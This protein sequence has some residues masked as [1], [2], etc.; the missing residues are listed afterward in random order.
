MQWRPLMQLKS[1]NPQTRRQAVEKLSRAP[2]SKIVEAVLP[3][4]RD[5]DLDVRKVAA[6]ALGKLKDDRAGAL[7]AAALQNPSAGVRLKAAAAQKASPELEA[8]LK[9]KEYW[10]RESAAKALARIRGRLQ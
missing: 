2:N 10:V 1:G 4:L 5:R 9:H 3:L 8:A 6:T 7:L